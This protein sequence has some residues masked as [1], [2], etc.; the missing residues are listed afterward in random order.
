[1]P[2]LC[3]G[4]T[5]P[6]DAGV[7]IRAL[8]EGDL[9]GADRVFR[10]AFGT[11]LGLPD[12]H[13]FAQGVELLRGRWHTDPGSALKA[14]EDGELVGCAFVTRWG[15]YSVFGPLAVHPDYWN[16]GVA[17]RLIEACLPRLESG[18]VT[19][20]SLFTRAEPKNVHLYQSSGFWPGSL[21]ALIGRELETV[22]PTDVP[23]RTFAELG[24]GEQRDALTDLR[25]ITDA[26]HGGLDLEREIRAVDTLG[27]G[28]A[29][30][31]ED[32]S[33]VAGFAV[34]HVGAGS[35][36]GPGTC[37]VKFGAVASGDDAPRLFQRLLDGCESYAKGRGM[38][39]VSAGINLGREQACR[40]AIGRGYRTSVLGVAMHRP[41]DPAWDRPDAYVIDDRR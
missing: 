17:R 22:P 9:P 13:R 4:M 8:E 5:T 38:S 40:I 6:T 36:A 28:D 41:S 37:Y 26:L 34:C 32:D 12:P 33:S 25:R 10:L 2:R 23:F 27:L 7:T 24:K 14:D 19:H 21:T 16:R 11:A 15:T 31:V 3:E 18:G 20:A 29:V 39:R 1:M 35:E 30:L